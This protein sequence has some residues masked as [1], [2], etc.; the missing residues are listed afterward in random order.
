MDFT[1][2]KNAIDEPTVGFVKKTLAG[3]KTPGIKEL[4]DRYWQDNRVVELFAALLYVY[5]K[6]RQA[7]KYRR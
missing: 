2:L 6:Q 3:E 5:E 4:V 7:G 1:E